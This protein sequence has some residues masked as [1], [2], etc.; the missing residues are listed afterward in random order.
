MCGNRPQTIS[1]NDQQGCSNMNPQTTVHY[2]VHLPE[3]LYKPGPDL[4]IWDW[5]S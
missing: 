2:D 4:Y 5:V 3:G 1:G